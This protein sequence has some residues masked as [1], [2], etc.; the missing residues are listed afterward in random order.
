M[1]IRQVGAEWFHAAD[2]QTDRNEN[3]SRFAQFC[4]SAYKFPEFFERGCSLPCFLGLTTCNSSKAAFLKL[5][6]SGDHFH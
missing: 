6:S 5:F 4:E 2:R 3:T 1:K